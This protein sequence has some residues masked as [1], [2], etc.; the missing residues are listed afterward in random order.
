[1]LKPGWTTIPV[2]RDTREQLK[3]VG[4]KGESYDSVILRLIALYK[5]AQTDSGESDR[6]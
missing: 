5:K 6:Q 3:D 2:S 1:M 4:R